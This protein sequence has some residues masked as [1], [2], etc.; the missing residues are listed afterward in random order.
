LLAWSRKS[1][2]SEWS[3]AGWTIVARA[4]KL[5]NHEQRDHGPTSENTI[6]GACTHILSEYANL[7]IQRHAPFCIVVPS[8][9]ERCCFPELSLASH[10]MLLTVSAASSES[11]RL[12]LRDSERQ[13]L[14]LSSFC[15]HLMRSSVACFCYHSHVL[16]TTQI[17][18]PG[19][20]ARWPGRARSQCEWE[21]MPR[22]GPLNVRSAQRV[23]RE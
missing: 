9:P 7:S 11:S 8:W 1:E 2:D 19:G 17:W 13:P 15:K 14:E 20:S 4:I 10:A 12:G 23:W 21:T 6:L 18:Q 3:A 22:S 5:C 16:A